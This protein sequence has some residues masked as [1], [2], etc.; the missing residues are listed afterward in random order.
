MDCLQEIA[1]NSFPHFPLP[2]TRVSRV[3]QASVRRERRNAAGRQTPP[4][5]VVFK[6]ARERPRR[7][8]YPTALI[9]LRHRFLVQIR[10]IFKQ[11]FRTRRPSHFAAKTRQESR[12]PSVLRLQKIS[13]NNF[14]KGDDICHIFCIIIEAKENTHARNQSL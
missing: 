3:L 8:I 10:P 1:P 11:L 4:R 9:P 12:P 13:P 6:S 2:Q 5:R 7:W 14:W